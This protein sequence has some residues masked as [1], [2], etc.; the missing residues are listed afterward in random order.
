MVEHHREHGIVELY[1]VA[2]GVVDVDVEVEVHGEEGIVDEKEEEEYERVSVD[3]SDPFWD[4]VLTD[5]SD[6]YDLD[7]DAELGLEYDDVGVDEGFGLQPEDVVDQEVGVE[8]AVGEAEEG[9][10]EGEGKGYSDI[11]GS[12]ELISPSAS[13]KRVRLRL[14]LQDGPVSPRGF[15]L[16]RMI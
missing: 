15:H 12:D 11:S 3:R 5:D 13:V 1:L 7:G 10:G 14:S 6:A 8:A 16:V 2:F 4:Q 9:E